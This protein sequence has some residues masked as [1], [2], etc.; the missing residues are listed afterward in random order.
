MI[1]AGASVTGHRRTWDFHSGLRGVMLSLGSVL[2]D[3]ALGLLCGV[4][5]QA[6]N[7]ALNGTRSRVDVRLKGGGCLLVRHVG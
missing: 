2:L 4:T 5:G 6:T 3:I 7:S 1:F